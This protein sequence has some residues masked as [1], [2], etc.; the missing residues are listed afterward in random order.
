MKSNLFFS[1]T[2]GIYLASFFLFLAAQVFK[3][4]RLARWIVPLFASGLGVHTFGFIRR[5]VEFHRL[6]K[7]ANPDPL[8]WG[9][10][11]Q[12]FP[13]TNLYESLILFA[14]AMVLVFLVLY[15]KRRL[16][17]I[18]WLVAL[19]AAS[20]MAYAA[21]LT[22]PQ[23]AIA[24]L[25]PALK[26]NWLLFHVITCFLAYAAFAV[27]A[28]LALVIL[29]LPHQRQRR[30]EGEAPRA[31]PVEGATRA[32][33]IDLTMYRVVLFGFLL[34]TVGIILGAVWANES[35]GSYWSWDPKETWSLITWFVFA[36]YLHARRSRGWTGRPAATLV[37]AGFAVT[38]FCYLGVNLVLSG[39]HSY[40]SP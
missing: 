27:A 7:E 37:L 26:S 39:L 38:L 29:F 28:A 19:L 36:A 5:V 22:A 2:T 12:F 13:V 21:G 11:Y 8:S 20:A 15:W 25:V 40:G 35:W 1:V 34:L 32:P 33:I 4:E 31:L 17:E 30:V 16:I 6:M 24:P 23:T 18:G 14:W 10:L 9:K 3:K